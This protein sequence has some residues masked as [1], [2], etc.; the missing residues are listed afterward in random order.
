MSEKVSDVF[1]LGFEKRIMF[2][3]FIVAI[4]AVLVLLGNSNLGAV[5]LSLI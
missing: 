5:I 4:V 2:V 1:F 3:V